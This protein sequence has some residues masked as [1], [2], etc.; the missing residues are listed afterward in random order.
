MHSCWVLMLVLMLMVQSR[1]SF[2]RV[3]SQHMPT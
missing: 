2:M 1:P 3:S